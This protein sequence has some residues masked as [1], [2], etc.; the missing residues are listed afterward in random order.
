M[1]MK[2]A[3]AIL[4]VLILALCLGGCDEDIF[5]GNRRVDESSYQID[6]TMLNGERKQVLP[7]REGD[8]LKVEITRIKGSIRMAVTSEDGLEVYSGDCSV[9]TSFTVRVPKTGNYVISV[10]GSRAQGSVR[11]EFKPAAGA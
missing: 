11:V 9:T 6:F 2:K 3:M 4:S 10:V 5:S 8:E 1:P 7:F